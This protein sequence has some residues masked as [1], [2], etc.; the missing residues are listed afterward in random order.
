MEGLGLGDWPAR[1]GLRVAQRWEQKGPKG[2]ERS[3]EGLAA[4]CS[5]MLDS[6]WVFGTDCSLRSRQEKSEGRK[7]ALRDGGGKRREA[8]RYC[9][10]THRDD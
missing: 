3:D 4:E 6:L 8:S 10:L 2:Q 1:W 9:G 5:F 7:A